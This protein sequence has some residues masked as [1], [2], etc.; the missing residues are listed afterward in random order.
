M[1]VGYYG[2]SYS[3]L[4]EYNRCE[5]VEQAA[6]DFA[7]D[8]HEI[9]EDSDIDFTLTV[10]DDKGDRHTVKMYTEFDPRHEIQSITPKS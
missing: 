2:V 4:S 3:D 6:K 9:V 8:H 10:I 5:T 1:K 7:E